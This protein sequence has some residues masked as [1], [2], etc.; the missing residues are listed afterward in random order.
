M[1]LTVTMPQFAETLT[2][3]TV[4]RWLKGAGDRVEKYEPLVEIL[5]DKVNIE[6]ASPAS[7][8]LTEIVA[9]EGQTI[10][11]GGL[12]AYIAEGAEEDT[13]EHREPE[14]L[15]AALAQGSGAQRVGEEK[16]VTP[17]VARLAAQ[18]GVDLSQVPGT[19]I[20]GR[21]TKQDLLAYV[22]RSKQGP[23][24][25]PIEAPAPAPVAVAPKAA[26]APP[27]SVSGEEAMAPAP[28]PLEEALPLTQV[29][30]VIAEHM[31]RSKFSAPHAWAMVEVDVTSLVRWRQNIKEEFQRREGVELTYLPFVVKIVAEAL[32]EYPLL[33]AAWAE[34]K[35]LLKKLINIGIAVAREEGLVVPVVKDAD[36]LSLAGL[37][38][39]IADLV[40]RARSNTLGPA[41][42]TGGTFTV[43]N[44]GVL[45]T[46]LSYPII[47]PGQAG[48]LT[49]EVIVKRAVV[50]DDAIA[51]RSI[52]NMCLAFDHRVLDGSVAGGFLRTVKDRLERLGPD[53]PLY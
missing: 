25:P 17:V 19:G 53:T 18:Y 10:P 8:R 21:V 36:R 28:A 1:A 45:G 22:E 31:V 29:R 38:H 13:Q 15:R 9:K 42:I 12:L 50:V 30:R 46:V 51:I 3:G 2:E 34:D 32:K 49:T 20:G 44:T 5:T 27:A 23:V 47:Y 43:N 24:G 7:G 48:I 4:G 40:S 39:A 33:N 52:M 16:R 26:P 14:A 37:A 41:E 11:V 6:M 35:I